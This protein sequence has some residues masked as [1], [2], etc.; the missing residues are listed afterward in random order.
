MTAIL[1]NEL[2]TGH[3]V[4]TVGFVFP[5]EDACVIDKLIVIG[6]QERTFRIHH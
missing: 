4:R 1:I 2:I 6:E 3:S 5:K